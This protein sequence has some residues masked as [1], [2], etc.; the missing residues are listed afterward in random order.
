MALMHDL[1]EGRTSD[2]NYVHQKYGRLSESRAIADLATTV[3]FGPEIEGLYVE[4]QARISKESKLVKDA[5]QLEWMATMR[6]EEIKGNKKA[7]VWAEIA[8]KRLKTRAGKQLG[9]ALLKTHPDAWWF[10]AGDTWFVDRKPKTE[11]KK[12]R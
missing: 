12:R 10:D 3:P 2:H 4:E 9:R 1:G 5:D 6:H 8:F 7:R 11:P